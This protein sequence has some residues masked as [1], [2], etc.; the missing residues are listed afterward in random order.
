MARRRYASDY[1]YERRGYSRRRRER[2]SEERR[3]E[4]VT[5]MALIVLFV[6]A[7]LYGQRLSP[8]WITLLGGVILTGSALYQSQRRW[9]VNPLT[10][11]GGAI[12]LIVGLGAMNGFGLPGGIF[13]PIAIF[14]VVLIGS[15]L[16]GEL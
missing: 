4:L 8:A 6:F 11:I 3:T 10:W 14:A 2:R 16:T 1:G 15:F 5:F 7:V 9:R 13:T 12:M